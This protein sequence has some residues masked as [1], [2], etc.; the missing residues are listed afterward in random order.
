MLEVEAS[1][2][3]ARVLAL[4]SF[5]GPANG[6]VIEAG[7]NTGQRQASPFSVGEEAL[8]LSFDN[9]VTACHK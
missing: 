3:A 7:P 5:K 8:L 4:E 9:S 2:K 6:A 1:G